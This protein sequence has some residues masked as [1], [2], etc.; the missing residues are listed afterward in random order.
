MTEKQGINLP[1]DP[2]SPADEEARSIGT[3]TTIDDEIN[4]GRK[5]ETSK[6]SGVER[7]GKKKRC[8]SS[9]VPA[10]EARQSAE[11][12]PEVTAMRRDQGRGSAEW[13]WGLL[14]CRQG[15]RV[16]RLLFSEGCMIIHDSLVTALL[17]TCH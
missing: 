4:S 6:Y 13:G 11:K 10:S 15:N 14:S 5:V 12:T 7:S 17:P 8:S 9:T 3:S 1:R 16:E 2:E